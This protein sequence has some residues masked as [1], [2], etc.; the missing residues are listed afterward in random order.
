MVFALEKSSGNAL[1]DL[2][3]IYQQEELEEDDVQRVL[4]VLEEVGSRENAQRLT[5]MAA[6]Q[7]LDALKP[8]TLPD[9]ARLEAE[10]LVDFLARREY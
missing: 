7:A 5:E 2:L 3:R 8:I 10:E 1:A 9:W 6:A 4:A